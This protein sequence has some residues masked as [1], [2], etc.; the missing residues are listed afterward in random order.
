[1]FK[2]GDLSIDRIQTG[3]AEDINETEILYVLNQLADATIDITAESKE[4]TDKDGNLIK[5]TYNAKSGTFTANNAMINTHILAAMSGSEIVEASGTAK[6]AMPK[7]MIVSAK[8]TD[9][10]LTDYVEGSVKVSAYYSNGAKGEK[11]TLGS[12]ASETEFVVDES[13]KLTLPKVAEGSGVTQFIVVYKRLVS[14]GGQVSNY[15]DKFPKTIRLTLKALYIDPC[16]V[17]TLK[18]VYIVLPSF[19]PS[20]ETSIALQTDTQLEYKGDLQIDYCSGN[21]KKLYDLFFPLDEEEEE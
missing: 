8:A 19:Q 1:M 6:I 21:G 9:I 12:V 17:D 20:P 14:A 10:T 4:V 15:S 11:Y 13:G 7:S 16:H 5:K 2:L 3:I 18:P